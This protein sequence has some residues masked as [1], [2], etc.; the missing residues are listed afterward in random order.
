MSGN[1]A[2]RRELTRTAAGAGRSVAAFGGN[3]TRGPIDIATAVRAKGGSGHNDFKSETFIVSGDTVRRL[4][5]R[6]FERLQGLPDDY[7][8]VRHRGRMA[9]D[10]PRYRVV[11]N[12]W[13]VPVVRWIG[14]RMEAVDGIRA[15]AAA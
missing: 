14:R 6:E 12:S 1:A 3:N 15:R 2:P 8:L 11:G 13:P 7:T 5:P 9:T 4:T 10:G